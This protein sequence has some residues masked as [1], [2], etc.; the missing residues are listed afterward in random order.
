MRCG[1]AED[2]NDG[3]MVDVPREYKVFWDHIH[4]RVLIPSMEAWPS[5]E[6]CISRRLI[7]GPT[8]RSSLKPHRSH[9]VVDTSRAGKSSGQ[10][11]GVVTWYS[12]GGSKDHSNVFLDSRRKTA[13]MNIH[14]S[15]GIM[16]VGVERR[17]ELAP[18]TKLRRLGTGLWA[19]SGAVAGVVDHMAVTV[20]IGRRGKTSEERR[21]DS[22]AEA[23]V[24][25]Q[26]HQ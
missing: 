13:V 3:E 24:T 5:V 6:T 21:R 1:S 23:E 17:G 25:G 14:P 18:R 9:R 10:V 8:L 11:S 22:E 7:D 16:M 26:L 15:V 19:P 12:S 20:W 2:T 4:R